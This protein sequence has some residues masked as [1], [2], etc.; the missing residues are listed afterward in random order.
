[1]LE[2]PQSDQ[3]TY[4]RVY[5]NIHHSFLLR[6]H[7][8]PYHMGHTISTLIFFDMWLLYSSL[9][10]DLCW[11]HPNRI[12]IPIVG[13][14]AIFIIHS[15]S[16]PTSRPIIWDILSLPSYFLICGCCTV[17]YLLIYVG[18]TPIGSTYLL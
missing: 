9:S 18:I 1:M 10:I 2:S 11:N 8:P 16:A 6:T 4:C 14:I 13:Y 7:L 17:H 3:H 12:N 15:Y 5:R